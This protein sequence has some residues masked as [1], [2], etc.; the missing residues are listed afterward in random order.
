MLKLSDERN[1]ISVRDVENFYQKKI[2]PRMFI[3]M[4]FYQANVKSVTI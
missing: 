3:D 2:F 1:C 4:I